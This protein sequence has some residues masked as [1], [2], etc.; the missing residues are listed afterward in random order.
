MQIIK[1]VILELTQNVVIGTLKEPMDC[2][3]CRKPYTKT[4]CWGGYPEAFS[5]WICGPC[6]INSKY[7][8][9]STENSVAIIMEEFPEIG[10]ELLER[11]I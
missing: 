8:N 11:E 7:L 9:F 2:C 1:R 4:I 6:Y 5:D 3:L 10:L